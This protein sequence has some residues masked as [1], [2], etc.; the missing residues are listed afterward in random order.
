MTDQPNP[1]TITL[2]GYDA[3]DIEKRMARM[4]ITDHEIDVGRE[5]ETY[6]SQ[7]IHEA[8]NKKVEAELLKMI[9]RAFKDGVIVSE[10]WEEEIV[11]KPVAEI[12]LEHA[13]E[14]MTKPQGGEFQRKAS[15]FNQIVAEIVHKE[16]DKQVRDILKN[17]KADALAQAQKNISEI[18]A[19]RLFNGSKA[20][21]GI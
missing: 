15:P 6:V 7:H 4:I 8:L 17:V 21:P 10:P 20:L 2:Q 1:I 16:L 5:I 9:R 11:R 18:V 12:V 19:E 14:F 13:T 3:S